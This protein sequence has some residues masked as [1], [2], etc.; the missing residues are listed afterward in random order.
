MIA[1]PLQH[2]AGT[3]GFTLI[4]LLVVLAIIALVAGIGVAYL[5]GRPSDRIRLEATARHLAEALR[6]SRAAAVLRNAEIALTVDTEGHNFESA[7]ASRQGIDSDIAVRLTIAEPERLT[8]A[9]GGFRFF[10]D[11]SSTG[12]EILLGLRGREARICVNWLSGEARQAAR[13]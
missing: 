7:A 11:G 9:R 6:V 3:T 13:C 10:P 5:G 4:E 1:S 12:G 2:R 8:S